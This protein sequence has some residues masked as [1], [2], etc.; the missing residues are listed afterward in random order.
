MKP[1]AIILKLLFST[2]KYVNFLK[3]TQFLLKYFFKIYQ[4]VAIKAETEHYR[5]FMGRLNEEGKGWTYGALYWQLNDVWV[6]PTWS[7]IGLFN[8]YFN[9]IDRYTV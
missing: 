3:R 9:L 6:A 8:I 4:A 2:A 7:G 1:A 5:S